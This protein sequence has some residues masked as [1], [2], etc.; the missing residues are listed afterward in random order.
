M[1]Q[2]QRT[3]WSR[4][5]LPYSETDKKNHLTDKDRELQLYDPSYSNSVSSQSIPSDATFETI[6]DATL[7][8]KEI[9]GYY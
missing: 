6:K 4:W 9:N 8:T 3:P 2:E 1:S 7:V 5:D